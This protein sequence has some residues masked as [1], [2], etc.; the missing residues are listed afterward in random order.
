MRM[1]HALMFFF[2]VIDCFAQDRSRSA[3]TSRTTG[4]RERFQD[5]NS[6][7]QQNNLS[8]K[9]RKKK[10][11]EKELSEEGQTDDLKVIQKDFTDFAKTVESR[12]RTVVKTRHVLIHGDPYTIQGLPFVYSHPTTG[13][14][15]GARLNLY[16]IRRVNPYKT[17]ILMQYWE[18]DLG[19]K[20]HRFG[21]DF[22]QFL[23]SG[24]RI[25]IAANMYASLSENYFG[26]G[27]MDPVDLS[28]LDPE[29][30]EFS[31]YNNTRYFDFRRETVRGIIRTTR[32]LGRS[33][34]YLEGSI[35]QQKTLIKRSSDQEQQVF[36]T[37]PLGVDGGTLR[38]VG[39]GVLQDTRDFEPYPTSG[40]FSE[41]FATMY[42]K[43][44]RSDYVFTRL[45]ATDR[46][47][48]RI[49]SHMVVAHFFGFET[50]LG[51]PPFFE[52]DDIGGFYPQDVSGGDQAMRGYN[53]MRFIGQIK[54]IQQL[55]L[56]YEFVRGTFWRQ[57]FDLSFVPSIDFT[58]AWDKEQPF[59]FDNFAMSGHWGFRLRWNERFI[60]RGDMAFSRENRIF[61]TGF[62]NTF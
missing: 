39:F 26:L 4:A 24:W 9:D 62:Q 21:L 49:R 33:S 60:L 61:Q 43:A 48:F 14:N 59:T 37:R 54:Y 10:I 13:F 11:T 50:I 8:A 34:F 22:P 35:G 15:V 31:K 12:F 44:L 1:L 19:R 5:G 45:T 51:K 52:L 38:W 7:A 20:N 18:S 25:N 2:L 42:P 41:L 57:R 27:R 17:G 56:R 46:R 53:T 3:T 23:D 58:R 16:N 30:P 32:R 6:D 36:I 55:E 28:V 40:N 29:H 47:Y